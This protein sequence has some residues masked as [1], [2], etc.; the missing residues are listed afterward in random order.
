MEPPP[1]EISST[2]IINAIKEKI[3]KDEDSLN[4]FYSENEQLFIFHKNQHDYKPALSKYIVLCIAYRFGI[5]IE[6]NDSSFINQL[7]SQDGIS[8]DNNKIKV[9]GCISNEVENILKQKKYT[10]DQDKNLFI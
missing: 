6:T 7:S 5:E 10:Y 8:T 9:H 4:K 1:P 3:L 2:F